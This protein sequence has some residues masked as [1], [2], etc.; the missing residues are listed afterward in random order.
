MFWQV[1]NISGIQVKKPPFLR[2]PPYL[3]RI[4]NKG[5][6]LKSSTLWSRFCYFFLWKPHQ[7]H[8]FCKENH[9]WAVQNHQKFSPAA[10]YQ[11]CIVCF[12]IEIVRWDFR[13]PISRIQVSYHIRISTKH[14]TGTV[15]RAMSSL[16][17]FK[18]FVTLWN[19][20]KSC[21]WPNFFWVPDRA[22]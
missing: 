4:F 8:C 2:N 18:F 21:F 12:W 7:K 10:S 22:F 20:Q 3:S 13:N 15:W 19:V 14:E 9:V 11:L 5:G 17:I 16:M 1:I 6:F